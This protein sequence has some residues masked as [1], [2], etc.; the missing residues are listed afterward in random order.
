M[1]AKLS[2]GRYKQAH[3]RISRGFGR[4][5]FSRP[6]VNIVP[7]WVDAEVGCTGMTAWA[8]LKTR[9]SALTRCVAPKLPIGPMPFP[10]IRVANCVASSVADQARNNPMQDYQKRLKT[11]EMR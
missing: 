9:M 10:A 7:A 2:W 4:I 11:S 3:S 1:L 8:C 6:D 5:A